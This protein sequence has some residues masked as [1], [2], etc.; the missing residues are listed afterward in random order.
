MAHLDEHKHLSDRQ[1]ALL[2]KHSPETQL[3][4]VINNWAK[5]L[6]KGRQVDTVILDFKKA[7]A[8]PPHELRKCMLYGFGIGG[9]TEMDRFFSLGQIATC[10]GEWS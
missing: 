10:D 4:T 2:K 6:D 3:I 5:I 8:T 7:L 1:H 9:K